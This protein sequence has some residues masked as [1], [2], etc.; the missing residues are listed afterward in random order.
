VDV[1][2][3]GTHGIHLYDWSRNINVAQLVP[4]APNNPTAA[5]GPQ[6]LE[7]VNGSLPYNDPANPTPLTS[8]V[9]GNS[10]FGLPMSNA[11]ERVN[12][13][14]FS[15]GG[16]ASTDA[17][18]DSLYNS[19]QAQV[20]HQFSKGLLLQFSY[21][22]SKE[23]TNINT[24]AAG[25]GIQPAGEVIFGAANS[26]SPLDLGQQYGLA[27]F[28]RSQ[29]AVISYVYDLPYHKTEGLSGKL[30]G[31]WSVSGVTEIQNGLPF[32]IVDGGGASI[33]GAGSSRALLADPIDCNPK[34]SCKSGIPMATSGSTTDRVNGRWVNPAAFTS[35]SPTTYA[36]PNALGFTYLPA[37]SPYCIGGTPNPGG[38]A[39]APC[40]AFPSPFAATFPEGA[41][42]AGAGTGYGNS[43]I[44]GIT[45]PG[46][47]NFNM[48]V[49]K[50]T[51]IWE[52]GTLEFH[53]DAFNVFNHAQFNPPYGNDVNTP[54]TFGKITSTSVT[55]RV[56]QFGLKYLF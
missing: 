41:T 17:I 48:S 10:A 3:L 8:N 45:G 25:S 40:G 54:A 42:F 4:G 6:N 33:Y 49:I 22:W 1:G 29:R 36:A 21:T 5:S 38:N 37:S 31:G 12:Y 28:N 39:N 30:L 34:R 14:G 56:M 27:A 7:M 20:R 43:P 55:P 2:Y 19:L 51:K 35:M 44:G 26:N 32:W 11:N 15:P 46:Q 23:L 9:V 18:G 53:T 47:F 13:L 50:T 24:S 16:V 52:H